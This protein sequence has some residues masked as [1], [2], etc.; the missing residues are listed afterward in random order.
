[1]TELIKPYL[2]SDGVFVGVQ[3]SMNNEAIASI[4][5]PERTVGCVVELSAE[6]YTPGLVQRNTTR[7]GSWF[8]VGELDGLITPRI[9][10]I[11]NIMSN[12]G[13]TE[14][15]TNISGAKWTKLI[16][17][18]MAMGPK[19]I[20]G[21]KNDEAH[22]FPGLLDIQVNLGKESMAVG[23]E[24]GYNIE[25]I[26]GLDADD[27]AGSDDQVL[28]TTLKT[29]T[30]HVG[31]RARAAPIQD[32]LKGRKTEMDYINGLV[33]I[34]GREIGVPTPYNDAI[35]EISRKINNGELKMDRSNFTLLKEMISNTT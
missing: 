11:R 21:Y 33:S 30:A 13:V 32:V 20:L 12:V 9:E 29:L 6:I 17:N 4:V 15:T 31:T 25:P 34:R 26:F 22:E 35:S 19:G 24:L 1:M 10:E 5:G 7:K 23:T 3:N 2:K 14:I 8:S 16:S 18:V 28:I 27:F